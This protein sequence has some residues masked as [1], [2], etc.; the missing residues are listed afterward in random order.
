MFHQVSEGGAQVQGDAQWG[1]MWEHPQILEIQGGQRDVRIPRIGVTVSKII[2]I[3]I[4][5]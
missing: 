4:Q 3:Q 1:D 5:K 2:K